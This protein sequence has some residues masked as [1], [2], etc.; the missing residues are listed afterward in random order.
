MN[1]FSRE[2]RASLEN[3]QT[4]IS[5]ANII[6]RMGSLFGVNSTASKINVTGTSALSDTAV[7][8]AIRLISETVGQL[9]LQLYERTERGR[10]PA[11]AHP[12]YTLL[13]ESPNESATST[14]W[15]ETMQGHILGF[16]NGY[17]FISR[18]TGSGRPLALENLLPD[19]TRPARDKDSGKLYY[20]TEINGKEYVIQPDEILHIPAFGFDGLQGRSP[21]TVHAETIGLSIAATKFGAEFF[22]NGASLGGVLEIEKSLGDEARTKLKN[23]WD[24]LKGSGYQGVAV[25]EEGMK[26]SRIAIAP[27]DA[28]FLE[29][30]KFQVAEIARIFNVPPHMLRDLEKSSFNNISEQSIEFLRYSIAPWLLKWEQ[31][32]NRKLLSQ[33]ERGKYFFKFNFNGLLRGTQKDRYEAY[34]KAINDGWLNRNEVRELEDLD[35]ED[36]LDGFLVPLNMVIAGQEPAEVVPAEPENDERGLEILVPVAERAS[37]ALATWLNAVNKKAKGDSD[38]LIARYINGIDD[39][40][41]RHVVP[42]L[43]SISYIDSEDSSEKL[44]NLRAWLDNRPLFKQIDA[45]E[46]LTELL[47]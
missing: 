45:K 47:K 13:H 21:I 37:E 3:P 17:S 11:T 15:R 32:L 41:E 1:L 35:R 33:N 6:E 29:T 36:D 7:Y 8:A 27:N 24:K 43:E 18:G 40:L 23:S 14:V 4:K 12:L 9:P 19:K 26:Y 30:R 38:E 44:I 28:Q 5:A 31:E 20:L 16:G 46:I 34:G 39:A 25:L 10:R 42:L 2:K 22:G